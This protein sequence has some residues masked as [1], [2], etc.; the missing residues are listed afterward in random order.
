MDLFG[1][2]LLSLVGYAVIC[3]I[4][5]LILDS[6]ADSKLDNMP[7]FLASFFFTPLV[8]GMVALVNIIS[9]STYKNIENKSEIIN[10]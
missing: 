9:K 8:G 4:L 7:V 5:V 3:Y 2:V 6:A 1:I 10:S